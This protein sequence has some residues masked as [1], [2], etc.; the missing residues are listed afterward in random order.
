MFAACLPLANR[1]ATAAAPARELAKFSIG[2][3]A[4]RIAA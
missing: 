3:S 2:G 4:V 1:F